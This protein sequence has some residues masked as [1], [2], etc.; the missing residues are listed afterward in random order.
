VS[1]DEVR[2][3]KGEKLGGDVTTKVIGAG[4][5]VG[6]GQKERDFLVDADAIERNTQLREGV[7]AIRNRNG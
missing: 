3:A 5:V 4:K 2:V 1:I 7:T 6:K